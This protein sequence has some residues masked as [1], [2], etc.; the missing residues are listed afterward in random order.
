MGRIR[1]TLIKRVAY[2]VYE[3]YKDMLTTDFNKNREIIDKV[4]KVEG[5]FMKNKIT[6]YVTHLVKIGGRNEV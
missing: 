3:K 6:G 1:S 5:K 2:E 4:V